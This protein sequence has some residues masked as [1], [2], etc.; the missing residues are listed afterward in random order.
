MWVSVWPCGEGAEGLEG[1]ALISF[2]LDPA[3]SS[4]IIST[5]YL[6]DIFLRLISCFV[7][8]LDWC[9]GPVI[10]PWPFAWHG[11]KQHKEKTKEKKKA[12]RKRRGCTSECPRSM[13]NSFKLKHLLLRWTTVTSRV[14]SKLEI[15]CL[16]SKWS[17][18]V[19]HYRVSDQLSSHTAL[20][21]VKTNNN[22]NNNLKKQN[23]INVQITT[24]LTLCSQPP[25]K[26][27]QTPSL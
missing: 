7:H 19:V 23:S 1:S 22:N 8:V 14:V 18:Y 15:I 25:R 10:M 13:F 6:A 21:I 20:L 17:L 27:R 5:L 3:T 12:P 9:S 26:T 4:W 24:Y 16:C 11:D 2:K